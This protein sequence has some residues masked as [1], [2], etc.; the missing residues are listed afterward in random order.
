MLLIPLL[1]REW[2]T[3]LWVGGQPDLQREFQYSQ[4]YY[5]KKDFL[6]R[7]KRTKRTTLSTNKQTNNIRLSILAPLY[8]PFLCILTADGLGFHRLFITMID[9]SISGIVCQHKVFILRFIVLGI[10]LTTTTLANKQISK[11][12]QHLYCLV[13]NKM[14]K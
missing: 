7:T 5:M 6:K 12:I 10:S 4:D 2:Q 11:V 14:L 13:S 1:G 8:V 9:C 3:D